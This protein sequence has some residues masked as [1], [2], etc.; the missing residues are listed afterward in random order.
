MSVS[1]EFRI[2]LT[3]TLMAPAI[4]VA[5]RLCVPADEL[6]DLLLTE[7]VRHQIDDGLSFTTIAR[8]LGK[9]RRKIAYLA[10]AAKSPS[11]LLRDSEH[12]AL[13]RRVAAWFAEQDE[14]CA[15]RDQLVH[16]LNPTSAE[17]LAR[18]LDALVASGVLDVKTMVGDD[19]ADHAVPDRDVTY[20]LSA[21]FMST[22]DSDPGPVIDAVQNLMFAVSTAVE[23]RFLDF[24]RRVGTARTLSFSLPAARARTTLERLYGMLRDEVLS[25][26]EARDGEVV[27]VFWGGA[28]DVLDPD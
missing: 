1:V 3:A 23:H 4:R 26:D 19:L 16:A 28:A 2:R 21:D 18:A 7:Y 25:L 9:S 22:V 6:V 17:A 15:T 27:T 24:P 14:A 10:K 5:H 12:F 8:R 13:R 20:K 11:E